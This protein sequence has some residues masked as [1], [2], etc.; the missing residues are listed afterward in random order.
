MRSA[1][2]FS[3]LFACFVIGQENPPPNVDE[4]LRARV[5]EFFG[6]HVKGEF[7][8]AMNLVAQ[9]TQ[10]EYFAAQKTRYEEFKIDSI[11]Y[12]DNF[13]KAVVN[14][15]V[16]E[17]KRLS[18][19]FP[20]TV[21]VE[22]TSVLWKVEDGKWCFY[23]DHKTNWMMPMGPSDQKLVEDAR[24]GKNQLPAGFSPDK[25]KELGASILGQSSISRTDVQLPPDRPSVEE[26]VFTNGQGGTVKLSMSPMKVPEGMTVE[27]DKT[28]VPIP[29]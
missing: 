1:A 25:I 14:L 10:D 18:V 3:L 2:A 9:E 24:S 17:K 6:Y 19:Q 5:N 7:R 28:D 4:A 11:R 12:T 23:I 16:K 15:T 29:Q 13:T 27:L 8:K 22:P 21:F 20:E 26:I